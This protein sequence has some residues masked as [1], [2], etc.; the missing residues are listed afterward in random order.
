MASAA[1]G[2]LKGASIG[3]VTVDSAAPQNRLCAGG[4][5][6]LSIFEDDFTIG[7]G[8]SGLSAGD[9]V[10]IMARASLSGV[11]F[12][13]GA[14]SDGSWYRFWVSLTIQ[15]TPGYAFN[16]DNQSGYLAP[17][18]DDTINLAWSDRIA[19]HVGDTLHLRA[20]L[21]TGLGSTSIAPGDTAT[22]YLDFFSA[23]MGTAGLGY[24][25]GYEDILIV[26]DAGAPVAPV[27]I[28]GTALLFGFGLGLT[29]IRRY[30]FKA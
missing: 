5:G 29:I 23:G 8:S 10:D 13:T 28:P 22:N 16:V 24:A 25:T 1:S 26:S 17:P 4:I 19:V 20:E 27:P 6:T 9:A 2:Q 7:A 15:G 11:V 21:R 3:S 30:F 18:K 14:G 12:L